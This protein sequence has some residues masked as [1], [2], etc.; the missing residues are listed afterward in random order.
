MFA[1]TCN[2]FRF[3][4]HNHPGFDYTTA[5]VAVMFASGDPVIIMRAGSTMSRRECGGGVNR[6]NEVMFI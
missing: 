1:H 4:I 2:H 5:P 3:R 6:S